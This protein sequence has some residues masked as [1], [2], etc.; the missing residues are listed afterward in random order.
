MA[1]VLGGVSGI[2]SVAGFALQ[3]LESVQKLK[4]F[5]SKVKH[6][7]SQLED[8]LDELN[9]YA[10]LVS[11]CEA[12]S[13]ATFASRLPSRT[14]LRCCERAAKLIATVLN[15]VQSGAQGSRKRG[16]WAGIKFVIKEQKIEENLRKLERAK[17]MLVLANQCLL[18]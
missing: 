13:T 15:D 1:E 17:S 4:R 9:L 2:I 12:A 5:L 6:A 8:L 7:H 16:A 10:C 14:P 11:E 3:I 18:Q